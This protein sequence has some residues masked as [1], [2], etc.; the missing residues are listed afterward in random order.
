MCAACFLVDFVHSRIVLGALPTLAGWA[1]A[2]L[3][4]EVGG[5]LNRST[6]DTP[7]T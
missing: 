4:G 3:L 2:S 5:G 6:F 7:S 1:S